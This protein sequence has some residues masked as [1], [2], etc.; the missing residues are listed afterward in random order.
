HVIYVYDP[1]EDITITPKD[2]VDTPKE[3][4]PEEEKTVTPPTPSTPTVT[5]TTPTTVNTTP[6][7]VTALPSTPAVVTASNGASTPASTPSAAKGLAT[8]TFDEYG[9]AIMAL[10]AAAVCALFAGGYALRRRKEQ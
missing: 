1:A 10:A 3:D 2:P 6:K 7:T 4:E 9:P 5:P 8:K